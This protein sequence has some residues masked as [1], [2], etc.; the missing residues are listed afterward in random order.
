[1]KTNSVRAKLKRGE[2]SLGTW[3][4]LPDPFA[5]RLMSGVGFD[6]LNVEL[7]H[8]PVNIETAAACFVAIA[9]GGA[10]PLA[11]VPFNTVENIKRVLDNGAWGVVVPMVN[12]RAEAEAAVAAAR[13]QPL[14]QRS[15][16]GQLHAAS[17]GADPATYYARANDEI[18]L[19]AM[20]EH[21][22]AVEN[23]EAILSV[24]G[25][26]AFFIGPNDL[27]NSMGRRPVF[28]SDEP[29]FTQALR[30]LL[31]V[32][33]KYGVASGIH[34]ADAAAAARRRAEGFQ[35]IAIAS[36]AGLMLA[37]ARESLAA[38]GLGAGGLAAKY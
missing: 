16:G 2:A 32:G 7:E 24:P 27:T 4:V 28:E 29:E 19:V 1:M 9:A 33:R 38:L 14:G 10:V 3:L 34:V 20:I 36:D 13:Y 5:A 6:W 30:H 23:A 18:L 26:D 21:V 11:R 35:M 25:V 12:S 31:A 37:K 8:A 17:F 22:R 15:V